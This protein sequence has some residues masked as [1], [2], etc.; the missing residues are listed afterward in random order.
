M[1]GGPVF[2]LPGDGING[3]M[4]GFH[5]P[6]AATLPTAAAHCAGSVPQPA[7]VPPG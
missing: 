6:T 2:G 4:E 5:L 7:I 1:G 3:L